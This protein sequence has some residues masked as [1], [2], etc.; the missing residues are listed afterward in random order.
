MVCFLCF[1]CD[2]ENGLDC[3]QKTGTI[4]QSEVEIADFSRIIVWEGVQ[5]FIQKGEVRK[6]IIETGE[7]LLNDIEVTVQDGQ[8]SLKNNNECNYIRDYDVTKIYVT[9][10]H[11]TEIRN[12][13][14]L[15]VRSIG[16]LQFPSLT[17]LSEDYGAEDLYHI[18]G[19]FNLNLDV[20]EIQI[21]SN[22]FSSFVLSGAAE[23]AVFGFYASNT[24]L[25]ASEL[26][27]QEVQLFHR[28][29]NVM[30][31]NPQQAIRG[32]IVSIGDVISVH[33]PPIVEVEELY[34][35]RLI[36]E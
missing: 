10:P 3:F 20:D 34:E 1:S 19:D 25:D 13:S 14:S 28:S 22:G 35:G 7:N 26:I 16:V 2:S 33:Q 29:S 18:D 5:L 23:R 8:L 12:S 6:V 24:R 9:T 11:L 27:A 36:F 17:L 31:V 30:I 21:S 4:I 32:E 15:E